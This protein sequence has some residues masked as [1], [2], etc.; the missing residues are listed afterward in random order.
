LRQTEGFLGAVLQRID[1]P[2]PYPEHTTL[3]R[4]HPPV[5]LRQ[6]V[7]RASAGSLSLIIDSSGVQICGQGAWYTQ[8]HGEKQPT[9]W[10]KLHIGVDAQG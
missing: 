7:D 1:V 6:Q 2:L 4:R 3:S 9:R 8:K 10:K 5:A